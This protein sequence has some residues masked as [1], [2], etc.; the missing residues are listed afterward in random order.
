MI[1]VMP[2][3]KYP[4]CCH[5]PSS[6]TQVIVPAHYHI[7]YLAHFQEDNFVLSAIFCAI[8]E[9]N[10][11]GLKKLLSMASIDVNQSNKQG[12]SSIHIAAGFGRLEIMKILAQKGANLGLVDHQGDSTIV[13]AARQGHTETIKYLVSQGVHLNM[14]NKVRP[15]WAGW[16]DMHC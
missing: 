2:I 7:D 15:R 3:L 13:W 9:D 14:I 6:T 4:M 12:E 10:Q 11:E 16:L 1:D 8:E 5:S